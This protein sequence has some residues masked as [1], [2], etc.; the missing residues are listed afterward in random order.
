MSNGNDDSSQLNTNPA[1]LDVI[2]AL[3]QTNQVRI[4]AVAY[5]NDINTNALQQLTSQTMGQYHEA[6]TSAELAVQF[7]RIAKNLDGQY[8]LRW[9]T[10]KRAAIPFVPSFEI[11]VD[12]RTSIFIGPDYNPPDYAGDVTVGGLRLVADA[13]VGPQTIRLR[14]TYVPRYVRA[15]RLSCRPN[16]PCTVSLASTNTGEILYGWGLTETNDGAG[17]RLLTLMSPDTTNLFTSITYGALGDLVDFHFTY[18][19]S[20]TATQAFSVFTIDNTIYNMLPPP[21]GQSFVLSNAS[22][23]I[24][25]YP[26]PPPHGTPIPWLRTYGFSSNYAAAELSDP[27]TNGMP[28]W[29]EYLAGLDPRNTNS[30]FKVWTDF[31]TGQTP[32]I[33]FSAVSTRT[34]RVESSTTLTNW[35]LL[36]D[37]IPGYDGNIRFIDNRNLSSVKAVFYRVGVY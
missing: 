13:E 34:Y 16:Y 8:L 35:V 9:S 36:R 18:P 21:N 17:L 23:F 19:D 33:L 10:L 4:Y 1:P 24:T 12:G 37:D 25:L 2:V 30:T 11:A 3:A 28:V 14:A 6:P 22:S 15:L 32:Q 26:A 31:T 7:S 29:Q 27:N 5:G 20:L